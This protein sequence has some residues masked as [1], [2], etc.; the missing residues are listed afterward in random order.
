MGGCYSAG[1]LPPD[2]FSCRLLP[3]L[4]FLFCF[5]AHIFFWVY[6]RL[7]CTVTMRKRSSISNRFYHHHP[8]ALAVIMIHYSGISLV[9]FFCLSLLCVSNLL[10]FL[11]FCHS[12][13]HHAPVN[14]YF[15][16]GAHISYDEGL[17][18]SL[19][20]E[21]IEAAFQ[22]HGWGCISLSARHRLCFAS[23]LVACLVACLAVKCRRS[24][25]E[26]TRFFSIKHFD[27]V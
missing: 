19:D 11:D 21:R 4:V 1:F 3:A 12:L 10:Y 20:R 25:S 16:E 8:C 24:L 9:S 15:E 6:C 13:L 5:P 23:C 17:L 14:M 27:V 18:F 2:P 7:S 22:I 26:C